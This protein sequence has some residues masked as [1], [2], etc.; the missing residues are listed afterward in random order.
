M[1]V[2]QKRGVRPRPRSSY[3]ST[4]DGAFG[5]S[6]AEVSGGDTI[7]VP[8]ANPNLD[9]FVCAAMQYAREWSP[10]R[11]LTF[12]FEGRR[13]DLHCMG[14]GSESCSSPWSTTRGDVQVKANRRAVFKI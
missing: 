13:L 5:D 10:S 7:G 2:T 4:A 11:G 12:A 8:L 6:W 1:E 3:G 9:I 14:G